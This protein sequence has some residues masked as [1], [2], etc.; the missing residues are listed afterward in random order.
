MYP[1]QVPIQD[2]AVCMDEISWYQFEYT[3]TA[4][5]EHRSYFIFTEIESTSRCVLLVQAW[6]TEDQVAV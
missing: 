4:L 3:R 1:V 5:V 6:P 2:D